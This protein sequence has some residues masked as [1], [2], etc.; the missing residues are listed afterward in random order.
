MK[1]VKKKIDDFQQKR[2]RQRKHDKARRTKTHFFLFV[3]RF[4]AADIRVRDTIQSPEMLSRTIGCTGS[5]RV[6][7]TLLAS[8]SSRVCK[9]NIRY[10][11]TTVETPT[12]PLKPVNADKD[13]KKGAGETKKRFYNNQLVTSLYNALDVEYREFSP[14]FEKIQQCFQKASAEDKSK[15]AR[16]MVALGNKMISKVVEIKENTKNEVSTSILLKEIITLL[17]DNKLIHSSHFSR[18]L[19]SLIAEKKY[20]AALTL[21]IENANYFNHTPQAFETKFGTEASMKTEHQLYGLTSYLLSLLE[22]K[23]QIDPEFIKLIFDKSKPCKL[24]EFERFT[25]KLPLSSED[26]SA[27]FNLYSSYSTK[28]FDI[29]SAESLKGI[30]LASVDGKTVHLENTIEKNLKAYENRESE[31][32]PDT[33]AHY[34]KYLNQAKLY[35]RAIELWKFASK[36]KIEINVSIWNQLLSSF[37]NLSIE[38]SKSKVESVWKLLQENVKPNSESYSI[39]VKYLIKTK[40]IEQVKT[41]LSDLKKNN[42]NLFDSNLKC[43]MVEYLLLSGKV[44]EALQLFN[45]YQQDES[46]RPTIEIYNKLLSKLVLEK[47][48]G[49]ADALLG[50]ILKDKNVKPD[51]ATWTTIIDL[52]L[53][54]AAKSN[55]TKEEVLA[56]IFSIVKTM[57]SLDVKFNSVALTMVATNLLRNNSTHSLGLSILQNMEVS[58]VKLNNVAYTAI[59]TSF[60]SAGDTTN[61]LYYYDKAINNGILPTAFLY[62]SI[63][64]GYSRNPNV[65]ETRK[66]M[67]NIKT[68]IKENPQNQKLLPNKYTFYFLLIQ[69]LSAKD[70]TFV[71]DVLKELAVADTELGAELPTILKLLSEKGYQV[72]EP[73]ASKI[74]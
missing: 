45:L 25:R 59:I 56:K 17:I 36:H 9:M 41:V 4:G 60:T 31:I 58:G 71:N 39:Y 62:N 54:N 3:C 14:F 49:E 70:R 40:N 34:M 61:A 11:S 15:C 69:G 10:Q 30:R 12:S 35:S 73:L 21:W 53:K 22:N 16:S 33:I 48:N 8:T 38:N 68:L 51:I 6:V 42:K 2:M 47:K 64:K 19:T 37:S 1:R 23:E 74:K 67:A 72:P 7:Q 5:K 44:T 29:N 43:S 46:F 50:D 20:M 32:K 52:L 13:S 27:I 63:L 65:A 57:E 26:R 66:F 55:L 18:Y 28:N 24:H